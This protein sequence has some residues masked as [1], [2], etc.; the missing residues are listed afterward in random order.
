MFVITISD[1]RCF[2]LEI[3]EAVNDPAVSGTTAPRLQI[4][5]VVIDPAV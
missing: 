4:N 2:R 3:N 5:E 1:V